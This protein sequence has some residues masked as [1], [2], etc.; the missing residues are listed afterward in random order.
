MVGM[1]SGVKMLSK[2]LFFVVMVLSV[3][4]TLTMA[5]G[6][7][8][9]CMMAATGVRSSLLGGPLKG[10]VGGALFKMRW[11]LVV[12]GFS[13][14]KPAVVVGLMMGFMEFPLVGRILFAG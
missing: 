11:L 5:M 4:G 6:G 8:G 1:L 7:F 12:L 3:V 10:H 2:M 13:R 9:A 14:V